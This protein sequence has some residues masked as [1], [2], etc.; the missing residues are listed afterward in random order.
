VSENPEPS[1]RVWTIPNVISMVRI[2]LIVVFAVLLASHRDGW[3]I[4]ALVVAGV[5]D[6]LDG[7]L[8]RRWNQVTRLG[9]ILDPAADRLLTLAV[10]IGLGLRGI[11]PWWLVGVLLARDAVVGIALLVGQ[12]ASAAAP[13]VTFVGKAATTG[14]YFFLPLS[15]LAYGHSDLWHAIGIWGSAASA[16]VYWYAGLGY[17]A[18]VARRSR[19]PV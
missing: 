8:A 2:A 19:P 11:V 13:Q 10:V 7:F 5:S 12:R 17:V 16:V 15:Y 18:D 9:R 3:A 6:F 1:S 14:L 4:T